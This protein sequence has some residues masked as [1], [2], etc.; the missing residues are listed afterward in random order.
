MEVVEVVAVAVVV[1]AAARHTCNCD[2]Q[3][4]STDDCETRSTLS[5]AAFAFSCEVAATSITFTRD[6]AQHSAN[7]PKNHTHTTATASAIA[8]VTPGPQSHV[9]RT[10]HSSHTPSPLVSFSHAHAASQSSP[11]FAA[12]SSRSLWI[13]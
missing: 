9:S 4:P 11:S 13:S 5:T 7:G 8:A 2:P 12:C 6:A 3:H 10:T 1:A